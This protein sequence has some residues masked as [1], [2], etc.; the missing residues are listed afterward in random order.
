MQRSFASCMPA[1]LLCWRSAACVCRCGLRE[2]RQK[3]RGS[4]VRGKWGISTCLHRL[5]AGYVVATK[6]VSVLSAMRSARVEWCGTAV[7]LQQ[8]T[9]L[10]EMGVAGTPNAC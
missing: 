7:V 2:G 4:L 10:S 1:Q 3:R 9:I 6:A 8:R 5:C